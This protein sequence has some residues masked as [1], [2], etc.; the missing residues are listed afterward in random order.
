MGKVWYTIVTKGKK[1]TP[2]GEG[3]ILE[4]YVIINDER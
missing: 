2:N 1:P 3:K 4:L